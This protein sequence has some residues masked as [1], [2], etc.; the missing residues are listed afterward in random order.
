MAAGADDALEDNDTCATARAVAP[1]TY[2]SLVVKRLDEDWYVLQVPNGGQLSVNM[3]FTHANGNINASIQSAC[4]G[5]VLVNRTGTT[6]NEVFTYTNAS[7]SDTL[8]MR[9][10]LATD[11]R[12]EYSF[13]YSVSTP[14][15]ANDNCSG[16]TAVGAGTFSFNTVGAT[17]STPAI[18]SSCNAA[19]TTTINKDVWFRFTAP[20]SGTATAATCGTAFDTNVAVYAGTTCPS[21][22]AVVACNDN[23]CGTAS[24]ATWD[25]TAGSTWYV[26]VGSP[27]SG[28]GAGS[29]VLSCVLPPCEGDLNGDG[30]VDGL[31]LGVTLSQWGSNGS[32][33][34]NGDLNVDGLD[35]GLLLAGW[36]ACN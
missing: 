32:A 30:N 25:V 8:L 33:D 6:N 21:G 36:G 10:Y 15:P 19:A 23:G 13:T 24:S 12:N 29:L 35:L 4:G 22:T 16:A 2:S 5:P 7:G 3:T 28:S 11:T 18:P 17:N 14:A 26:R 20:C 9:V 31:D 34:L 1:G 27:G